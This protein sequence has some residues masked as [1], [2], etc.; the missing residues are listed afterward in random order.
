MGSTPRSFA[1]TPITGLHAV[2]SGV[3]RSTVSGAAGT[4]TTPSAS[5]AIMIQ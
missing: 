3:R 2:R 1:S 5:R 4:S